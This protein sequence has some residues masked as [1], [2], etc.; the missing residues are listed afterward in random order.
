[1]NSRIHDSDVGAPV[2]PFSPPEADSVLAGVTAKLPVKDRRF[3]CLG[4][5]AALGFG[6]P[7]MIYGV[8]KA[9]RIYAAQGKEP[10]IFAGRYST[11]A[12]V[13]AWLDTHPDFI[14][15]HILAPRGKKAAAPHD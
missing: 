5:A 12:R 15:R 10:L 2:A 11:P 1:M 3:N 9:N 13:A 7:W 6:G 14:A 4:L 8:K